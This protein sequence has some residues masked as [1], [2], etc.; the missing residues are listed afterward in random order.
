MLPVPA[1]S[2]VSNGVEFYIVWE[3]QQPNFTMAVMGSRV[4]TAG[5]KL[6]GNGVNISGANEPQAYTATDLVWDGSQWKVTWSF[7][8]AVRLARISCGRPGAG[9]GRHCRGW[10]IHR[11]NGG[12]VQPAACSL[13]GRAIST[14]TT[15]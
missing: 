1:A 10:P 7:N 14:A 3:Q 8:N 12:H 11:C 5:Q 2:L 15:T 4:N 6:D 9:S 13:P